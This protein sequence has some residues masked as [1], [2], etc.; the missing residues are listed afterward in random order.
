MADVITTTIDAIADVFE[1]I[2]AGFGNIVD[3]FSGLSSDVAGG[4]DAQ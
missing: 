4:D 2:F 1:Q 3:G